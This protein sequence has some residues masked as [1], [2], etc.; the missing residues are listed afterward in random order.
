MPKSDPPKFADARDLAAEV[1]ARVRATGP[2]VSDVFDG[3]AEKSGLDARDRHLAHE[4]AAG[5][6]RH[7]RTLDCVL[8]AYSSRP[9]AK[10]PPPLRLLCR[11]GAYQLLFLD[12]IP[13][14]AAVNRAVEIGKRWAR[15]RI[16]KHPSSVASFINGLLRGLARG[17]ERVDSPD[18]R[19][20]RRVIEL[21]GEG[22]WVAL[23]RDVLP[24]PGDKPADHLADAFSFTPWLT[25]R[26]IERFGPDQA[27]E[28][29]R[30]QN[31]RPA[32]TVRVNHLLVDPESVRKLLADEGVTARPT[33][34]G[35][36]LLVVEEGDVLATRAMREGML[37]PQDAWSAGVVE[38]LRL[39]AGM[40]VLD[41]CA[42]PGTKTIQMAELMRDNG[43]VLATD[44]SAEGLERV[45][46]AC[47]RMHV[48]CVRTF[49][50]E[51]LPQRMLAEG[52]V[53][54]VLVDA[55]CSNT[56][57]LAR[58][59][60]ARW[61]IGAG[62]L[63]DHAKLQR[64]LLSDA[65]NWL[66]PGGRAVYSTCSIEPEENQEV[67]KSCLGRRKGDCRLLEEKQTLPSLKDDHDGGY[68]AVIE[69]V[70]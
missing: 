34:P 66:V 13:E 26:W 38:R 60:E 41:R 11:L 2:F 61:R 5:V 68:W 22:R 52:F 8:D 7:R 21:P 12:R 42:A 29:A 20:V 36:G 69:R 23:D 64:E 40:K 10:S 18:G 19:E 27:R 15:A 25:E 16:R 1:L 43:Q 31:R 14:H 32:M 46:Q 51:E 57:V 56:G 24:D 44:I 45:A 54:R 4:L 39:K 58:R 17:I 55:P 35:S 33:H 50:T 28:I 65:L 70:R 53:D 47:R 49:P 48:R 63:A 3:L 9:L 6:V 37:Q 67:V 59:V 62:P 30:A